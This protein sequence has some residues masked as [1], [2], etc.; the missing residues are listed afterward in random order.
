MLD[1]N[2][3][4]LKGVYICMCVLVGAHVCVCVCIYILYPSIDLPI[5]MSHCTLDF[6]NLPFQ[7]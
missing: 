5:V 7:L 6:V 3:I 2:S 4:W 1:Y